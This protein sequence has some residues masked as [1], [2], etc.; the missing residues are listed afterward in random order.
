[1]KNIDLGRLQADIQE[2]PLLQNPIE[3]N[4]ND[5]VQQYNATIRS[6]LDDHGPVIT[7]YMIDRTN[8]P[9]YKSRYF[10]LNEK[11]GG[12]RGGI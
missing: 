12:Q 6:I 8:M 2:S 10:R 9:W 4:V 7:K 11:T 5:L 1:M 3:G